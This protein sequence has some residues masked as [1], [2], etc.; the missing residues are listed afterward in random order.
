M[1]DIG[2]EDGVVAQDGGGELRIVY[3]TCHQRVALT[4]DQSVIS[5]HDARMRH[6]APQTA[7][8]TAS[9]VKVIGGDNT[10]FCRSVG[11]VETCMG[12]QFAEAQH[13]GMCQR[14]CSRFDEVNLIGVMCQAL[15]SELQEHSDRSWYEEGGDL[16]CGIVE[17]LEESIQV[18]HA[19]EDV[20]CG[21]EEHHGENLR[22]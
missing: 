16:W 5:D 7:L 17:G 3:I 22:Q 19:V 9:V 10:C 18:A 20:E 1:T 2:S 11:V 14:G 13:I 12:Q 21:S 6:R 4:G 15:S 8:Q